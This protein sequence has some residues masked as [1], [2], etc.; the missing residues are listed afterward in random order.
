[1]VADATQG[2]GLHRGLGFASAPNLASTG[3][4]A[5][6]PAPGSA[7][8]VAFAAADAPIASAVQPAA[9]GSLAVTAVPAM[10]AADLPATSGAKASTFDMLRG[11]SGSDVGSGELVSG[12]DGRSGSGSP[13][14][15]LYDVA[16]RPGLGS[17][18]AL[19]GGSATGAAAAD[20]Q[21]ACAARQPPLMQVEHCWL[22]L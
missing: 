18:A 10:A 5:A 19:G 16:F 21:T 3:G 12:P 7:A 14:A 9:L 6:E 17:G 1:M 20:A 8:G 2:L 15:I 22:A 4:P 13:L 11:A